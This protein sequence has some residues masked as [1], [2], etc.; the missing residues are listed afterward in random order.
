MTRCLDD[1]AVFIA[2]MS[3]NYCNSEYCKLEIEEAR[4]KG[5][6]IIPIFIEDV[7][8]SEMSRV[9]RE[10]F[11]NYTRTK[12]VLKEGIYKLNLDWENVCESIIQYN[13]GNEVAPIDKL[14]AYKMFYLCV[15]PSL[16]WI[17]IEL[18]LIWSKSCIW[19]RI[20]A[21]SPPPR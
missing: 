14:S 3:K 18:N 9:T 5:M 15:L 19:W 13:G 11:R 17:V 20:S 2:V 4:V 1:C 6:S 16:S 21:P 10:V 12:F 7:E 8:E